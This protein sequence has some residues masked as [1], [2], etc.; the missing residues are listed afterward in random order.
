MLCQVL[1]TQKRSTTKMDTCNYSGILGPRLFQVKCVPQGN[2][3]RRHLDQ[4]L[5]VCTILP[6][7]SY[8][9]IYHCRTFT[10]FDKEEWDMELDCYSRKCFSKFKETFA[11]R[12][13]IVTFWQN[14]DVGNSMRCLRSRCWCGSFPQISRWDGTSSFQCFTDIFW[15]PKKIAKFIKN[16]L[17]L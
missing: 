14:S 15:S 8:K 2:V 7:V 13:E 9:T 6:K 5:G 11:F 1:W 17:P 4:I 3:W 12:R 10:P 16:D